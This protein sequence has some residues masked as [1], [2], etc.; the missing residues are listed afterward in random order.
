[1]VKRVITDL[2]PGVDKQ[3][4]GQQLNKNRPLFIQLATSMTLKVPEALNAARGMLE[5][6]SNDTLSSYWCGTRP[7]ITDQPPMRVN[8]SSGTD[9]TLECEYAP[10]LPV[11][12]H[13]RKDGAPIPNSNSSTLTLP[14]VNIID[15]GNYTCHVSNAVGM[16]SS[17]NVSVLAY[18][19]PRFFQILTPVTTYA[20]NESGA[21]FS[22]NAGAWPYPGWRWYYRAQES[23]PWIQFEG[24]DANELTISSPQKENEGWYTCEAFNDY[25]YLRAPAVRL[26]ILPVS[27]AQLNLEIKFQLNTNSTKPCPDLDSLRECISTYMIN[28]IKIGAASIGRMEIDVTSNSAY[29]VVL[30]FDKSECYNSRN[31]EHDSEGH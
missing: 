15:G 29:D 24:E 31:K 3:S 30:T 7:N 9:L 23:D 22:C 11:T 18:E 6:V 8:V 27:V 5:T 14:N 16:R 21:W 2:R 10:T 26:T 12:A 13:W 1:M 4:L 17:L 19:L 25:G 20:G 28:T